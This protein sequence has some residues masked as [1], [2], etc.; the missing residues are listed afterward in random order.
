MLGLDNVT[1]VHEPLKHLAWAVIA[2]VVLLFLLESRSRTVL[3]RFVSPVMQHR[4]A[5]RPSRQRRVVRL[6]FILASLLLGTVALMRPQTP[7]ATEAIAAGRVSADIMVVLDVSRSMLADDA[8]PT[9]LERAKAEIADMVGKLGGHRIGLVAFAGRAA[10]LAPLT[11]DYTFFRMI[12]GGVNT[13]SV[14]RGGT[15]IGTALGKAIDAFDPGPG[16]KLILLITDGEDQDSYPLE[17]AKKALEQGIRIVS[18]GIGSEQGSQITLVDPQTGARSLL[19]DRDNAPVLSRLDGELLRQIALETEGAYVP[20]GVAAL[21]ME[22]IVRTHI[23]PLTRDT[24]AAS[25]VRTIPREH[26]R[27]LVLAA[28]ACLFIAVALGASPGRSNAL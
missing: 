27:W 12:L 6:G 13:T 9:R 21:D 18:I 10:V 7:G 15:K 1:Y 16:A 14:S 22:S 3:G 24:S 19:T 5:A 23:K 26:Y 8:A 4:L 28:L 2:F 17:A 20:A 11:P 25:A